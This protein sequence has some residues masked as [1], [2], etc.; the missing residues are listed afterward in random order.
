MSCT[1]YAPWAA[2]GVLAER[3][4]AAPWQRFH[5]RSLPQVQGALRPRRESCSAYARMSSA[6]A[7]FARKNPAMAIIGTWTWWKNA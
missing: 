3:L 4:G 1:A 5:L 6:G 7:R 2:A